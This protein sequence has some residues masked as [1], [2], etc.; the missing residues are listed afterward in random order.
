VSVHDVGMQTT[1]SLPTSA[2]TASDDRRVQVRLTVCVGMGVVMGM[3]VGV[4][5]GGRLYVCFNGACVCG[6]GGRVYVRFNGACG[7]G[8]GCGCV[9]VH[10]SSYEQVCLCCHFGCAAF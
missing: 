8:C 1:A 4:G 7:C 5:V 10:V 2:W 3:G 6:V 9:C